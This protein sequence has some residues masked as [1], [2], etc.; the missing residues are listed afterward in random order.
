MGE[1]AAQAQG[2]RR[3][4]PDHHAR[5]DAG[6]RL[7]RALTAGSRQKPGIHHARAHRRDRHGQDTPLSEDRHAM[8]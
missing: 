8:V 4:L 6:A 7:R 3:T 5:S 1:G 2:A